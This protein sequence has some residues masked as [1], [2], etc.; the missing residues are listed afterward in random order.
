M[1]LIKVGELIMRLRNVKNAEEILNS[2]FYFIKNPATLRGNWS[3]VFGNDF[4][5]MLEIGMGKGDFLVGMATLH[6]EWNF[7]GIEKYESVLVRGVQKL[8]ELELKNVR[9]IN[10]DAIKIADYFSKEIDTIYLNFSDPWP[11]KRHYKRRLTYKDFL[12]EY[13]KAFKENSKIEMKTDND[14]LFESSLIS[15]NDYGYLFDEVILDLWSTEK[16]NIKTEY[17][18]K[19]SNKGFKIKY[20]RAHKNK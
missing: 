17:E 13:D 20:L 6:P 5:I 19:F 7:I 12:V 8:D 2:S 1:K 10:V 4:P 18:I 15:L 11:K 16:P 3:E 9:V 14:S